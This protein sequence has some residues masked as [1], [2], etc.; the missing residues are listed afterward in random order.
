MTKYYAK[1][2]KEYMRAISRTTN[3]INK[4]LNNEPEKGMS[5]NEWKQIA[6][7]TKGSIEGRMK[8]AWTN[9]CK[10]KVIL[11]K[12]KDIKKD[13]KEIISCFKEAN[14][15]LAIR[16]RA[17]FSGIEN[18]SF[19]YFRNEIENIGELGNKLGKDIAKYEKM[20]KAAM[21]DGK[22][23]NDEE[24]LLKIRR[25]E[26]S[27]TEEKHKELMEKYSKSRNTCKTNM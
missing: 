27:I 1:H 11:S 3:Q 2:K 5:P 20:L 18:A 17:N 13:E 15:W 21:L 23:S 10:G 4:L 9:Y 19:N 26:L 8:G 14:N 24:K 6:N 7:N 12:T 22:L 16:G 25:N